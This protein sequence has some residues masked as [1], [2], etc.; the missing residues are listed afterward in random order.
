MATTRL[1]P[2]QLAKFRGILIDRITRAWRDVHGD[3]RDESAASEPGEPDPRDEGDEAL[4]AQ[5]GDLKHSLDE[6]G[7]R[8]A[9]AMEAALARIARGEYGICVDCG[10]PIELERLRLVPWAT[11]CVEDQ[12]VFESE[13]GERS[14]SL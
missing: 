9:Q 5:L 1:T 3:V 6:R 12:Q 4:A 10:G 2:R 13:T 8:L 14:P 7:A 11:R